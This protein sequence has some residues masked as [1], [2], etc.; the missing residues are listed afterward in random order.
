MPARLTLAAAALGSLGFVRELK[1]TTIGA[2]VFL[3]IW[4]LLPY[5]AMAAVIERGTR[6][7]TAT[8]DLITT[9][10]VAAGGLLFLT[11]VIFV[12]PD[13]QGGIA[14]L[15]TPLYQGIAMMFIFPISRWMFRKRGSE[16]PPVVP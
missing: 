1:P 12:D 10:L 6:A 11:L 15:F 14:V 16:K 3:A 8:A 5:M 13:P 2:T 7:A 9:I 4:L